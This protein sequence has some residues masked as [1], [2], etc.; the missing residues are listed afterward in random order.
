MWT[1]WES[2]SWDV[3]VLSCQIS[4]EKPFKNN[5]RVLKIIIFIFFVSSNFALRINTNLYFLNM[6]VNF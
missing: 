5:D 1:V 2:L 3:C 4:E 6:F